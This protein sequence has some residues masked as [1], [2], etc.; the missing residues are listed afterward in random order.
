MRPRLVISSELGISF[1]LRT[2]SGLA[3]VES[4][5]H[6]LVCHSIKRKNFEEELRVLYVAL[7][8]AREQLYVIGTST[9]SKRDEYLEKIAVKRDTVSTYVM[10]GLRSYLE[11][12]LVAGD[13]TRPKSP[14]EF[15]GY[16]P[17]PD[18]TVTEADAED[19][20]E[21]TVGYTADASVTEELV[22][23]FTYEYP[24]KHLSLLPEKLSVSRTSPNL[25]DPD[26]ESEIIPEPADESEELK[27]H[28]PAFISGRA[29]EES[30]KRGIATHYFMQFCDLDS[31]EKNGAKKELER[32]VGNGYISKADGERVRIREIEAFCR[33]ELFHDMKNAKNL[34]RELRFNVNL[35][36]ALFTE[37]EERRMLYEGHTVL[38][39]G[40]I[41]CII[42][43]EDGSFGLYDY[44]TDRLSPEE[45]ADEQLAAETL[46][47][48][49][50][51]QLGYYALAV[52]EMF[53]KLPTR[54]EVYSLALGK[55]VDVK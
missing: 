29:V 4:P 34:Y 5:I 41:D 48:K 24:H 46:R 11:V 22:K 16:V 19:E 7:T 2:P 45:R 1:R 55:C 33:S 3:L 30:A 21:F 15:V 23:R 42:E 12:V 40:V 8:R 43:Y 50:S 6:D 32:L 49:H 36:A 35:P 9:S 54:V 26:D 20:A 52:K 31:L 25:L 47:R 10:R 17:I 37:D 39:Q 53:G 27:E 13:G 51:Q 18:E 28:V 14:E 44:K 38:V